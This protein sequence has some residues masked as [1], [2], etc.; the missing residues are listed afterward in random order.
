[1]LVG[2]VAVVTLLVNIKILVWYLSSRSE[3]QHYSPYSDYHIGLYLL[4]SSL[5]ALWTLGIIPQ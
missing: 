2:F 4:P 3:V 5:L 1:M